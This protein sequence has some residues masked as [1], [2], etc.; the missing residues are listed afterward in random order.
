MVIK[1]SGAY[2]LVVL[3]LFFFPVNFWKNNCIE[4]WV[5][6]GGG[7]KRGGIRRQ[8][9]YH[10]QPASNGA[11][12]IQ[13]ARLTAYLFA[14]GRKQGGPFWESLREL[15]KIGDTHPPQQCT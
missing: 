15:K 10:F 14:M 2:I 13:Y 8:V 7:R 5:I 6:S 1:N 9:L 11:F 3:C 12:E 4:K